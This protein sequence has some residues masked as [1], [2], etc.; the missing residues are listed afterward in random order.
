MVLIGEGV[1]ELERSI[2]DETKAKAGD[3][4]V[5]HGHKM[6]AWAAWSL[7]ARVDT[8]EAYSELEENEAPEESADDEAALDEEESS[9]E[10]TYEEKVKAWAA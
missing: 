8:K 10:A 4:V 1:S 6:W 7:L 3:K 5:I 2:L 9:S